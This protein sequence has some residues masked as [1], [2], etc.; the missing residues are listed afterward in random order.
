MSFCSGLTATL[1]DYLET[2]FNIIKQHKVARSMEIADALKVKRSTVTV[3]LRALAEKGYINYEP[4]SYITLTDC[5]EKAAKC[6]DLRH[7]ILRDL[8]TEVFR[9]PHD[10]SEE[11][12]CLMEHGM[13]TNVC[14]AITNLIK[15]LRNNKELAQML[16]A[17]L[18]KGNQTMDCSTSCNYQLKKDDIREKNFFDLNLL[19]EGEDAIIVKIV[20]N[21]SLK[22]KLAEMGITSGQKITMVKAAPL[23]DPIQIKVRNYE[24]MLRREEASNIIVEKK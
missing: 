4:R 11:T 13:N 3:A 10:L 1:E 2:I 7:H 18:E 24:L 16:L 22:R 14:K 17:E 15:I 12:A 8:F 5:G 21:E 6:I 20:G 19:K 9:L 23:G